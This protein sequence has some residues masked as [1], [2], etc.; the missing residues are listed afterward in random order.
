MYLSDIFYLQKD[1]I[2]TANTFFNHTIFPKCPVETMYQ[3]KNSFFDYTLKKRFNIKIMQQSVNNSV[4]M[5]L[6]F[7]NM[8]CNVE[9]KVR[10][11]KLLT[12]FQTGGG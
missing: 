11:N 7:K 10:K 12:L 5:H 9:F 8:K 3:K 6:L 4:C 1:H 2:S